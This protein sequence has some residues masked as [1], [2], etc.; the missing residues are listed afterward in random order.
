MTIIDYDGDVNLLVSVPA[1]HR[2][3]QTLDYLPPIHA[4]ITVEE[5]VAS[6]SA[7]DVVATA[8]SDLKEGRFTRHLSA[9]SF[10]SSLRS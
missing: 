7:D 9:E 2:Y 6:G 1:L 8:L 4:T 3:Q 10:L 5:T